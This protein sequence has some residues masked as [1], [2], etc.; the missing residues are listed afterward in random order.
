MRWVGTDAA[1]V[2]GTAKVT[3]TLDYIDDDAFCG[4][5]GITVRSQISRG[6]LDRVEFLEGPAWDQVVVVT[7][8]DIPRV[9]ADGTDPN[10]VVLIERDQPFL[11][12]KQI[13]HRHEPVV[14]LAHPDAA[15][16][17]AARAFVKLHVTEQKPLLDY[18]AQ[19]AA[20]QIQYGT[21]N[22][23]KHIGVRKGA[24]DV[25]DSGEAFAAVFSKAAH[26]VEGVYTTGAQEQCYIEPQGMVAS[27]EVAEAESGS[28][29][30]WPQGPWKLTVKGSMQCPYYVHSALTSLFQLPGSSVRIVQAPT[31]GGF[32]GKEEYPSMLAGHAALLA[33]KARK[34]VKM[35]YDRNED[36]LATTKRHPCR[37]RI[38][39]ALNGSGKLLALD[40]TVRM[41][42]GAYL[43][44]S[45]VVLSRG[46]IHAAGPYSVDHVRIDAD[47]VFTNNPPNG[48]FRGFGAPQ[49]VFAMERHL[50][51]CAAKLGLDPVELRRVNLLRVGESLAVS[52]R[53]DEPIE[54]RAWLDEALGAADY[55]AKLASFA[56]FNA[57]AAEG[58]DSRRRGLGV[59]TF[60]HGA[61]FT[62]SG[63]DWLASKVKVRATGEGRVEVL[64]ANTEIG[65][66]ALTVFSQV[67]ADALG[68]DLTDIVIGQA[69]TDQVPDSGPTVASRTSMVVGHLVACACDDLV[70]RM[71][72]AGLLG[73]ADE[74]RS[75]E[76]FQRVSARSDGRGQ[77]Y[78]AAA[79]R[80]ALRAAAGG[81][82]LSA[83]VGW[84]VYKRAT[85]AA[86]DD[87]TYKGVAYGTYA[88]ATYVAAVEV[89]LTS[90]EVRVLD[91]VASQEIGRVL[92]PTLARGQIE[93]GVVQGLG[94][95]LMEDVIINEGSMRN[96]NMTTY[97]VP[98]MADVPPIRVLFQEQPYAHGPYGA[99]GIGELPMDGPAPA[100]VNAVCQALGV[101]ISDLPCSP[102]RIMEALQC[103]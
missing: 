63:E 54:L 78:T 102:E 28:S 96:A 24:A 3:G 97:V 46:V 13:H 55:E 37:T 43:T 8:E 76:P 81:G 45:P 71:A 91:F 5:Y 70:V 84:S 36:M 87:K 61:G 31:G 25:A 9:A 82:D 90:F 21:D 98:T 60:M 44:L 58:G 86:W 38:R 69:D 101:Q 56:A 51:V 22:V 100:V 17:R 42:G 73:E 83:S 99:K 27:V 80:R 18:C 92:N 47:V 75:Q 20:E 89:D 32:G 30:M 10:V 39:A 52:Q 16:A 50:D 66:G 88:W 34:P 64:T 95:A 65:Q 35:V 1:R 26:V 7:H 2:D 14:L 23:F 77:H 33:L 59:A 94:W 4:L 85:D 57:E 41:D 62:G 103:K 19:P 48:A 15:T 72:N 67:A 29:A 49:T 93:G 74:R 11:V 12:R 68:L 40:M 6:I 79:L 53:I